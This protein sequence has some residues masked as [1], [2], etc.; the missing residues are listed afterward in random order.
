VYVDYVNQLRLAGM[1]KGEALLEAGSARLRPIIMTALTTILAMSTIALGMGSGAEMT[2]PMAVVTIGGL[3][4][5][6]LLTLLVVPLMYDF[7]HRRPLRKIEI[8]E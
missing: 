3:T 4:Y 6:T 1:E 2:Q 7:L 8:E 5:A